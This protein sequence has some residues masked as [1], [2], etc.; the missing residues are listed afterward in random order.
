MDAIV[1]L[2]LSEGYDCIMVIVDRLTKMAHFLPFTEEGFT[3]V[4][5]AKMMR[6]IFR[7]HGIPEDIV[8][9]RG[10]IFTSKLWRAFASGLNIKLN[11]S[12]A[13]HP[14]SDG[15]TER[16]N[17]VVEQYIRMYTNSTR[18]IG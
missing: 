5:L 18:I 11:F 9:D 1:K 13:Y 14:Q 8:S 17:Q 3:S 7:L 2:P 16:V 6:F 12:T 10:P 4:H 15:Q